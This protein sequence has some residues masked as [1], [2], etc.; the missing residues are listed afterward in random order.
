MEEGCPA[1]ERTRED[2]AET[3]M[4]RII[5]KRT[6][7]HVVPS[8]VRTDNVAHTTEAFR[9]IGWYP[10]TA[11]FTYSDSLAVGTDG[12]SRKGVSGER[13]SDHFPQPSLADM[14]ACAWMRLI[15]ERQAPVPPP[16]SQSRDSHER[17][18]PPRN[19][20]GLALTPK[21]SM[22]RGFRTS[23]SCRRVLHQVARG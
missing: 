11:T 17:A 16:A 9:S 15:Y 7:T 20:Q 4:V 2:T 19:L 6:Q 5:I 18:L 8:Y 12:S 21:C 23:G 10:G 3:A 14:C 13:A 1:A 22:R